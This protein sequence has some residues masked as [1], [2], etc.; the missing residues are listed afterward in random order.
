MNYITTLDF[1]TLE[2]VYFDDEGNEIYRTDMIEWKEYFTEED[3]DI[4]R[5]LIMRVY[6][7]EEELNNFKCMKNQI[8]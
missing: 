5:N 8:N 3:K 4:Y 1:K 2:Y 6:A 7:L